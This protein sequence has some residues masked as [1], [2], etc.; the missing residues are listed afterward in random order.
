M[1]NYS[2]NGGVL[3]HNLDIADH[4]TVFADNTE[5]SCTTCE[6]CESCILVTNQQFLTALSHA[7][8]DDAQLAIVSF[9]GNPNTEDG[10]KWFAKPYQGQ[11]ISP[12]NNNYMSVSSYR[13]D[14]AGEFRR[15][16]KT[17]AALH[18][19]M[20]DDLGTKIPLDRVNLPLS[21]LIKTSEG[22]YQGGYIL[23]VPITDAAMADSLMQAVINA[24]LCDA[25]ANG[26]TAR[27]GRLPQ[28]VNG[29]KDPVFE[30]HMTDWHPNRY[31]T[32]EQIV[33]GLGLVLR[34]KSRPSKTKTKSSKRQSVDD[35]GVFIPRPESNPVIAALQQRNLYKTPLGENKHDITCPWVHEHTGSI[36]GGTAYFEPDEAFPLGGFKCQHS[37]GD[38]QHI[39]QLL[40]FLDIELSA[41][42][43]KPTIRI[44]AGAIHS[45]VDTAER[46]LAETGHC[47]QTGGVMA[48]IRTD[49][50]TNE[51]NICP[52]SQP[53]LLRKLSRI[54]DWQRYDQRSEDWT[55]TDPTAK[56]V[57][58]LYDA[59]DYPHL[60]TLRGIARQPHLCVDGSLVKKA[61]YDRETGLFGVF[62]SRLYNIPD[63]PTK[64]DALAALQVLLDLV[65]EVAFDN[66]T[67]QAAALSAMLTAAIRQALPTAPVFLVTAHSIGSGK[68]FLV[69]LLCILATP[70]KVAGMAFPTDA[71]EMRK[72]LISELIK[73]P[74]VINFDDMSSDIQPS[75]ALKTA[76]TESFT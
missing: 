12:L 20:L 30:C 26:V 53:A 16:K 9:T 45:I 33:Q 5:E 31:Y 36:D 74:P 24:G 62:D 4:L 50:D 69:T 37:H 60:P 34:D 23:S 68:S 29:K 73:S 46:L 40:E 48:V 2:H 11:T 43:M 61:G 6:S 38:R 39:R 75:D 49:A 51:T 41:A 18:A 13:P 22:N 27:L 59:G 56:Y 71:D 54:A 15:T 25:G 66:E 44:S 8:H 57:T 21:W 19:I 76:L 28:G 1:T 42:K 14:D 32:L 70:H 58:V 65:A 64:D 47:Y 52:I 67:D 3:P 7:K 10:G 72:T 63:T 35:D 17:F 55:T